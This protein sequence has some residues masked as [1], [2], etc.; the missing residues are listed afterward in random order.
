MKNPLL[1]VL[2]VLLVASCNQKNS[3]SGNNLLDSIKLKNIN[4]VNNVNKI[5][6]DSNNTSLRFN[7]NWLLDNN[8]IFDPVL[9]FRK[10][11]PGDSVII[12]GKKF[13]IHGN[14]MVYTAFNPTPA[15]GN[16]MFYLD[17]CRF[18]LN[19]DKIEISFKGGYRAESRFDYIADYIVKKEN[20]DTFY[21]SRQNVIRDNKTK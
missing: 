13:T 20:S 11:T 19:E 16:G 10:E 15:C 12:Y 5:T 21:L 18:V 14:K 3:E 7:G 4:M 9:V 2:L 17:S 1:I 8:N 6:Q